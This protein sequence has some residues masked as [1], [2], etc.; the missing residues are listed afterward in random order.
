MKRLILLMILVAAGVAAVTF[1]APRWLAERLPSPENATKE[2]ASLTRL[3]EQKGWIAAYGRVEPASEERNLAFEISGVIESVSVRE[4]DPVMADQAVA[5]LRARDRK[6]RLEAAKA[7]EKAK[8]AQYQKLVAG[9]RKEEKSSAWAAVKRAETVMNNLK[10]EMLRR[11]ELLNK[12]LIAKEEV[13]RAIKDYRVAEK[14]YEEAEQQHLIAENQSRKEDIAS[15][16]AEYDA[17][18]HTVREME[19]ELEKTVL[20]SPIEGTVLRTHRKAGE[21]V[22]I[23]FES[24]VL[25]VGNEGKLNVRAEVDED[26][27]VLVAIGQRAIFACDA[28]PDREFK[29]TVTRLSHMTGRKLLPTDTPGDKV[30]TKVLEVIVSLEDSKGLITGITG[31]VLINTGGSGPNTGGGTQ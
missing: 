2:Y 6:A 13:D 31:D 14:Q 21:N 11:Q 24:P 28:F 29:G 9:A 16:Y 12:N 1:R 25:T 18:R 4:G 22:S 10:Q 5:A 19:A 17:A 23:F 26:F 3:E 30:D 8:L 7:Q 15:S 27:A 20:R